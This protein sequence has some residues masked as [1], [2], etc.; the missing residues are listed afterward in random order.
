MRR[1]SAQQNVYTKKLWRTVRFKY[2]KNQR[3]QT[4]NRSEN[5][6][7][8]NQPF[9]KA[10]SPNIA[11]IFLWLINRHFPKSH[12]LHKIFN[13]NTVKVS[14]SCMQNMS[15][16]YKG[17][18]S[19]ATYAPCNR[20]TFCNCPEKGQCSMNGIF[21]NMDAVYDCPVTLSELQKLDLGVGTS[22]MEAKVL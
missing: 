1:Y 19:K 22:K 9:N 5:I 11:K 21:Q 2:T 15:K 16:I 6:V 8:F 17:H 18:N 7:W 14:Y 12:R 13:R 10:A 3:Q 4:K 20:L